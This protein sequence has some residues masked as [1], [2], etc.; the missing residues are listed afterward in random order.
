MVYIDEDTIPGYTCRICNL[1]VCSDEAFDVYPN[2]SCKCVYCCI[3]NISQE[4]KEDEQQ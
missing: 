4:V 3:E 1:K 2:L